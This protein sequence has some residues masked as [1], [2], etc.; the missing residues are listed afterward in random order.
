MGPRL[1]ANFVDNVALQFFFLAPPQGGAWG[2]PSEMGPGE[3]L[4]SIS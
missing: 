1:E 4:G 3:Y 2:T